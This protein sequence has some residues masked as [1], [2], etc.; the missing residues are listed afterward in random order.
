MGRGRCIP[1]EQPIEGGLSAPPTPPCGVLAGNTRPSAAARLCRTLRFALSDPGSIAVVSLGRL[2]L[3]CGWAG[4]AARS[5]AAAL[6]WS[7]WSERVPLGGKRIHGAVLLLCVPLH[8]GLRR[9]VALVLDTFEP[10]PGQAVPGGAWTTTMLLETGSPKAQ[11]ARVSCTP[12]RAG[13]SN[14]VSLSGGPQVLLFSSMSMENI[15]GILALIRA[16]RSCSFYFLLESAFIWILQELLHKLLSHE[17][18]EVVR[19]DWERQWAAQWEAGEIW[20][21]AMEGT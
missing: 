7:A 18:V 3:R 15:V 10:V 20:N 1:A 4:G 9:E 14:H 11:L 5:P 16:T 21:G 17:G 8:K 6:P 2:A 19:Q 13:V 12:A